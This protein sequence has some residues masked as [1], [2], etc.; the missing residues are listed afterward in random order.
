MMVERVEGHLFMYRRPVYRVF[1]YLE[2]EWVYTR[3]SPIV[4]FPVESRRRRRTGPKFRGLST[5]RI[6]KFRARPRVCFVD[7]AAPRV[8][9]EN[10]PF[11][12]GRGPLDISIGRCGT[13]RLRQPCLYDR[14]AVSFVRGLVRLIKSP[15]TADRPRLTSASCGATNYD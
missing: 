14:R 4:E 8:S 1:Q 11:A 7:I 2:T 6:C 9:M 13:A 3:N 12:A 15:K 10:S 5:D